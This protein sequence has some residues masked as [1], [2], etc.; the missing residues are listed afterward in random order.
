MW[1]ISFPALL[2]MRI[3]PGIS[4][5]PEGI[6]PPSVMLPVLL[7]AVAISCAK[8]GDPLPP[9]P[10]DSVTVENL[11]V[12]QS[13]E[14]V[15]LTFP[16]PT[17]NIT[18]IELYRTCEGDP[19]SINDSAPV[20]VADQS[21]IGQLAFM[22]RLYVTVPDHSNDSECIY[23]IRTQGERGGRSGLS[24]QV[25]WKVLQPPPPPV[26]VSAKTLESSVEIEWNAPAGQASAQGDDVVEYLV[27]FQK[28]SLDNSFT[29]T[30][31]T[32]GEPVEFEV[33][34]LERRNGTLLFSKPSRLDDFV[35]KDRFPPHSPSGLVVVQLEAGMQLSWD[36]NGDSDL[37]GYYVYRLGQGR[38]AERISGLLTLNRFLDE[39][40]P[41]W[42]G[43]AYYVT[44]VDKWGNESSPSP[45]SN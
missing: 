30:E 21:D 40:P 13:G 23:A 26:G 34:T 27:N 3:F 37:S 14:E 42:P 11:E 28:L 38:P 7:L 20:L 8:V 18:A 41:E 22:D 10:P 32:F 19:D 1:W 5:S 2:K 25:E 36:D 4:Y 31:I 33:R 16:T 45:T 15:L 12:I 6:F 29:I 24:N 43:L 44:A 35:A 17:L 39:N 9:L